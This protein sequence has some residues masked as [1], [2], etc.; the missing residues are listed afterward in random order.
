[1][2]ISRNRPF[3]FLIFFSTVGFEGLEGVNVPLDVDEDTITN[4][5]E[6]LYKMEESIPSWILEHGEWVWHGAFDRYGTHRD[7][8]DRVRTSWTE[9]D[10]TSNMDARERYK[11][12]LLHK[13]VKHFLYK[14]RKFNKEEL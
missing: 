5:N 8:R 4:I 9:D 2:L 12:Y 10:L 7:V 6:K 14:W 3:G 1:M 13:K 11:N